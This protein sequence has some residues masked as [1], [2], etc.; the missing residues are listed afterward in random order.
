MISTVYNLSVRWKQYTAVIR[1]KKNNEKRKEKTDCSPYSLIKK[2]TDCSPH[3]LIKKWTDCSPHYLKCLKI[4]INQPCTLSLGQLYSNS[5]DWEMCVHWKK[6]RK[7]KCTGRRRGNK[8]KGVSRP[9]PLLQQPVIVF[10]SYLMGRPMPLLQQPVIVFT[11]YLMD[12]PMPL[13][14]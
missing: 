3:S 13:L 8:R 11:S 5:G 1:R 12:R 14:Q 6:K 7:Q 4:K 10:T 2:W 9:M